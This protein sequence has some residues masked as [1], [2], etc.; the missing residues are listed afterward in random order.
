MSRG[1]GGEGHRIVKSINIG[2]T[3]R[4]NVKTRRVVCVSTRVPSSTGS[5]MD[6][7]NKTQHQL[8][9]IVTVEVLN[10][11]RMS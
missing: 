6:I 11:E 8:L 10:G 4:K 9:K 2:R 1:R 3:T 5:G 7:L